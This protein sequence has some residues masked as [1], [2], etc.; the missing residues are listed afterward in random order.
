MPY[1]MC[2]QS[3]LLTSKER[4]TPQSIN[5]LPNEV[6]YSCLIMNEYIFPSD[7]LSCERC[8][9]MNTGAS[10]MKV[11]QECWVL[12]NNVENVKQCF[13][14]RTNAVQSD[15]QDSSCYRVAVIESLRFENV[16]TVITQGCQYSYYSSMFIIGKLYKTI[17]QCLC[18]L[19]FSSPTSHC[20]LFFWI[21]SKEIFVFLPCQSSSEMRLRKQTLL[22]LFISEQQG[23]S[24]HLDPTGICSLICNMKG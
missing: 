4:I 19:F 22:Y 17:S 12:N 9:T 8:I 3:R 21:P 23:W 1:Y 20:I 7:D 2:K 6:Y 16:Y 18:Q 11:I 24:R 10:M 13:H 5:D 15:G 14:G